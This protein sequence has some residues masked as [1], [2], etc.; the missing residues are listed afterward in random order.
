MITSEYI[1]E[2]SN[3]FHSGQVEAGTCIQ[4]MIGTVRTGVILKDVS[5]E[6][7]GGELSAVLGS[8]GSGK[9]ALLE[10]ISRR[11]QGPTRGQ[12]LLNGV[13]MSMRLFQESCGYVTQKCDLLPGLTVRQTLHY[14]AQLTIGPKVSQY[15]K[16]ARVKQVLA[17]LALSPIANRYVE[18][19]TQ[20]EY[21]RLTIGVQ[22]I[23]DPVVLLL[24]EPTWGLDPLNTYFVVS[25]LANYA[26]KYN[27]VVLLSME[28]PRSDIF[29]FL[30][31]VTYLCLGDVVY[32]GATR[33]MLDY[34]RSIGFPCPE[35]ENPLMYYLCLS[36]VDRR[37]RERFIESNNQIASLVEK[38]KL[39]GGAYRK[40]VGPPPEMENVE[41]HQKIPLTAY[42]RPG[43]FSVLLTLISRSLRRMSPFNWTGLMVFM[44]RLCL[45]PTFFFLL[46]IFYYHGFEE[47]SDE[48]HQYQRTFVTRNGLVFNCLAG[49]Y[50]TGIIMTACTSASERLRYYQEAREGIYSGP[51][52]LVSQLLQMVP[53]SL[54]STLIGSLIIFRGLKTELLCTEKSNGDRSCQAYSSYNEDKLATLER[55]GI[56]NWMEYN[57]YPDFVVYWLT[58]WACYFL[59]EQQTSSILIVVKSSYTAALSSIYITIVY[60]VLGS[61]TVRSLGSLPEI[62]YHLTYITQSRYTGALLNQVEFHDK[63][64][65]VSLRWIN[66]TNNQLY[67]CDDGNN[68]GFGCRYFNGTYY[69]QEKYGH[70]EGA[71]EAVMST[72]FNLGLAFVFP[73]TLFF[74]N[75]ILYLIPLPA[76]IKA[77]F[78]E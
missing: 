39:E 20:S 4:K 13:P 27:R 26:K 52:F 25:I 70:E 9:R 21:R 24:D 64:S 5:L 74:L 22:L 7:H 49:A 63:T 75:L 45:L 23:R 48:D 41:T 34:F 66:D 59:A 18:D 65:L 60:L 6:V 56:K 57:Y 78:R 76:F 11:A 2:L 30:D 28:K 68:F 33:M 53:L 69:L 8:K 32:T 40:Y 15:V 55:E 10:V 44:L 37:S 58:L 38:F 54:I 47:G 36:T 14:V 3:V 46:W 71:V 29:P 19:L 62:L 77:K 61:G 43:T 31:R 12:I 16:A 51:L 17:D 1:L 42:G 50:F 67:S 73:V 35:L 72:W